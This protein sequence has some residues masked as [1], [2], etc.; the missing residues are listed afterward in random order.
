MSISPKDDVVSTDVDDDVQEGQLK[1]LPL[2]FVVM[3]PTSVETTSS[4]GEIDIKDDSCRTLA[5]V[6]YSFCLLYTSDAAD[7]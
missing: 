7:E 6:A 2:A 5:L 1:Q 4:F 3:S